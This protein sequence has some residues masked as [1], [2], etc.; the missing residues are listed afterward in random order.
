MRFRIAASVVVVGLVVGAFIFLSVAAHE[1][2]VAER[3]A[4]RA[5][6]RA[7]AVGSD[8]RFAATPR[9]AIERVY[10]SMLMAINPD[11]VSSGPEAMADPAAGRA[12]VFVSAALLTL[13]LLAV[14]WLGLTLTYLGWLLLGWG[15][16]A[17]LTL[18]GGTVG[19]IG[20]LLVAG[21]PLALAFV[22]G[23]ELLRVALSGPWP[24]MAVARNVLA[25]AVRMKISLVFIVILL[26][27]LSY[28]PGALKED[29][30]LRYRVQQWLQYGMGL[31]YTVLA[32]LT[33]FLS[34]GTVSFEQRDRV[35][36]QTMTKPVHP[37]QY[38]AGKWIGVMALNVVLL[39]VTAGGVYMFTE[40]LRRQPA[41]GELAYHVREDG[42]ATLGNFQEMVDDRRLLDTQVL[43]AR[44]GRFPEPADPTRSPGKMERLV[45]SRVQEQLRQS[46][47]TA[48]M[49]T[50]RR[51]ARENLT[52][53]W[54]EALYNATRQRIE[55]MKAR[56]PSVE[57]GAALE[58]RIAAEVL[59]EWE[60][61]YRAI[62][63]GQGRVY[64]FTNL[65]P[66]SASRG[67]LMTLSYKIN[68]GSNDPSQIYRVHFDINDLRHERQVA[69]KAA[70]TLLFDPSLVGDD[71][72]LE[73]TLLNDPENPR[74]I[75]FAPD[76]LEVLYVA[77][78]YE[79]NFLRIAMA[80]W[81]KLAFVAAVGI[82]VST[83][84]SFP[85][86]C[87]VG[88]SI[89][90][91]AESASYL[92][93]ALE[94]YTSMTTEGI[95]WVAVASRAIAVPVGWIFSVYSE[96]EPTENL[97]SGRL[98]AWSTLARSMAILGGWT[99]AVL[100]LGLAIFRQRELAT[101]SGR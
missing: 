85:V 100:G 28:L 63:P 54:H 57:D 24:V 25:E 35:I 8:V 20:E 55:D 22:T 47:V 75:T 2:G 11:I 79:M 48:D 44:V 98:V 16:G 59:E 74:E 38:L 95:D 81:L 77:G 3:I 29:Q 84:L 4:A 23:M 17:P 10:D 86:A 40:Y 68:A 71:G 46:S 5:V 50:L 96:L 18:V 21:T 87:L 69:L 41:N 67:R 6:E 70:Q 60:S 58:Q 94:H 65:P 88:G 92:N 51:E 31:S 91:M 56:D 27:L 89:L 33:L 43:V 12:G 82:S 37:W 73:V 72:M 26:L 30:P 61:Q 93:E 39:G 19:G 64:L 83:F 49:A 80:M 42:V 7:Q 45:E 36:W 53:V 14:V 97:I 52:R 62:A 101:Y 78:G 15:I 1:P 66:P 76:G 13:G 90:F 32:L 9:Q 99:I 34:A